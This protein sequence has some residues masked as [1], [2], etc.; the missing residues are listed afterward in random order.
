MTHLKTLAVP[1]TWPIKRKGQTFMVRPHPGKKFSYGLPLTI[2]FKNLMKYCKTT[3]EVKTILR[4]NEVLVD[5]KRRTETR[6]MVGIMDVLSIPLLKE[7]YRMMINTKGKLELVSIEKEESGIK[8][9]KI[10]GKTLLKKGIM[11]LN[12][13]DGRNIR[14]KGGDYKVGD[15]LVIALPSQ[16]I[17]ETL[18]FE[19][20][21]YAYLIA[22]GHIGEHGIVDKIKDGNATIKSQDTKFETPLENMFIVGKEKSL[23][24]LSEK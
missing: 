6:Y 22:G 5:G 15:S 2:I 8:I 24:K 17:K 13:S 11:Q 1:P 23:I 12:L 14:V 20:G 7:Y 3:K 16:D 4:E 21:A 10:A 18:K 19:D 9:V